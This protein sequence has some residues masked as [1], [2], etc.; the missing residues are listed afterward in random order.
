MSNPFFIFRLPGEK[1]IYGGEA[2]EITPG[3]HP[4][5]FYI[6]PFFLNQQ[7]KDFTI[8]SPLLSGEKALQLISRTF[9]E[10]NSLTVKEESTPKKEHSFYITHIKNALKEL[11]FRDGIS[12]K[13]V[14]ARRLV[15]D[16]SVNLRKSF[17]ALCK[18]YPLA[19]IFSFYSKESGC[20]IGASPELFLRSSNGELLTMSLAGTRPAGSQDAWDNKNLEEQQIVT[21][22]IVT[23]FQNFGLKINLENT[24]TFKAGPVEHLQSLIK[25]KFNKNQDQS[26]Q[27][28]FAR[29]I[30]DLL[31]ELSPTPALGGYPKGS[32]LEL[33][34][35]TE[36]FDRKYY[37]G[38]CG[39]IQDFQNFS[40]YVNLR[41]GEITGNKTILYAG[42][43][44]THLSNPDTEWEETERKLSTLL[45]VIER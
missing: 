20:W 25:G 39:Y 30:P 29:I 31:T 26:S 13:V 18:A 38:F 27:T 8:I 10:G 4:G 43:G 32:A 16:E 40:L 15:F 9:L 35:N 11:K 1:T 19:F 23:T 44:I 36:N 6:A 21:D 42:G 5:G 45:T 7:Y 41:C 14:I 24:K 28:D 22:Y 2:E 34:K 33:I 12:G 17:I 3:L 37:G